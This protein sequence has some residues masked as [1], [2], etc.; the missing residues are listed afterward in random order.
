MKNVLIINAH[1]LYKDISTGTLNNS[2]VEVMKNTLTDLGCEIKFTHIEKGYEIKEEVNKHLWA[3]LIITQS[4]VYWFGSPWIYKKYIDEVFT[5]GM[6][7]G[8]FLSGDGRT[9]HDSNKQYGSGGKL[10]G[11]KY[12]LSL[13]WNAPHQAFNDK[14][15]NLFQ[16]K[17]VDDVFISNTS[18]YKFCGVDILPTFSFFDVM[19]E[20]N[21]LKTM[22]LLKAELVSIMENTKNS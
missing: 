15:Q 21:V 13:T 5:E 6:M 20:P 11:K 10:H 14:N 7:Q 19:K 3:D 4:P 2:I 16:G 9:R 17:S 22:N 12:M 18:N 8:S 1:Q